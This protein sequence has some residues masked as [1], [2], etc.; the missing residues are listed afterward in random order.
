MREVKC[1]VEEL[2]LLIKNRKVLCMGAGGYLVESFLSEEFKR[3]QFENYIEAIVDNSKEKQQTYLTCRNK[4]I[5]IVSFEEIRDKISLDYLI[6][7]TSRFYIRDFI[8][9]L[10]DNIKGEVEYCI[11]MDTI[12]R[13]EENKEL[14]N[15]IK[16]NAKLQKKIPKILHWCWFGKNPLPEKEKKC[17]ESWRKFCPDYQVMLWNE[18][19]FDIMQNMYVQEAYKNKKWAFVSDY[20]RL[21]SIYNYGGIYLDADV[22]LFRK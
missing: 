1:T 7:I 9:Q 17:I 11:W 18:E 6:I 2:A 16:R 14:E 12:D 19:N 5:S 21:W 13:Y 22:E 15:I 8:M 20:V 4:S 3:Y 10:Q